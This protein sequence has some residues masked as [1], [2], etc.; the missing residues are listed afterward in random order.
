LRERVV[1]NPHPAGHDHPG[2]EPGDDEEQGEE[3]TPNHQPD[4]P[5]SRHVHAPWPRAR[6]I[7]PATKR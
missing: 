7:E 3:E 2:R 1:G 5:A 6:V 4:Y